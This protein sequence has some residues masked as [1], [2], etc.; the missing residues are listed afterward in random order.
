MENVLD[1]VGAIAAEKLKEIKSPAEAKA[2]EEA[3]VASQE[4]AKIE[5]KAKKDEGEKLAKAEAQATE[6]ERILTVEDK[7]LS[8]P[9]LKR[10]VELKETKKKKDE[11]PDE[12]I[13]RV[14]ES[15]QKRIDEIKSELLSERELTKKEIES[16]RAELT[17]LKK[18]KVEEDA[19]E[20]SKREETERLGK[21]VEEDKNKPIA[22]R[23]EM[24]KESLEA[25]YLE[26]PLAATEWIQ[27]R[28]ARR[29]EERK[30][31]VDDAKPKVDAKKLADDFIV[32]QNESKAK[33][34][35]KYPGASPSQEHIVEIKKSLGLPLD[36]KLDD[37]ELTKINKAL[38]DESEDYR[39]VQTI[40]AED[41]KKYLGSVNG[42]ELVMAEIDKRKGAKKV[43]TLT[44]EELEAK[45]QAETERRARVGGEGLTSTKGKA[46][47]NK[48]ENKSDLRQKQEMIAKKAKI[49]IESLDKA[50]D[51][52]KTIPGASQFEDSRE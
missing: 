48:N 34:F 43:V 22:E 6:D 41:P 52:R 39:L 25:W 15:S 4:K 5:E 33:L 40:V 51:R 18:P 16:L 7:D 32:K 8:E 3:A 28:T 10:K 11:S 9:E 44:E 47:N 19:R 29:V 14:Q 49:S 38:S 31:A 36:R 12:K 26:D 30:K 20:K 42:P 46:V 1:K 50:I 45:I 21:Y 24:S 13:K 23:R 17:E 27:E 37:D 35:S 2:K